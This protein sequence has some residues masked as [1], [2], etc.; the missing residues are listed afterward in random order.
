MD[1]FVR[2]LCLGLPFIIV[3]VGTGF[4]QRALTWK[5]VRDKFEAAN[6]TLRAGQIGIDESRVRCDASEALSW[7]TAWASP[8]SLRSSLGAPRGGVLVV[9]SIQGIAL[10]YS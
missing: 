6:P 9:L 7:A 8:Q 1:R 2:C 10:R 4:A 3:C 5:Q